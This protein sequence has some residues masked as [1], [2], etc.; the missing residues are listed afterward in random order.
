[1]I[2]RRI[3]N[4]LVFRK[5]ACLRRSSKAK[6]KISREQRDTVILAVNRWSGFSRHY[7]LWTS[8]GGVNKDSVDIDEHSV[9]RVI[10]VII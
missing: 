5:C 4:E 6:L 3:R 7:A 9:V 8:D 10:Y 1:M 2:E